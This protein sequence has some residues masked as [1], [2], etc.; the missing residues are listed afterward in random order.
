[1]KN[2]NHRYLTLAIVTLLF[3]VHCAQCKATVNNSSD[4]NTVIQI[5]QK[6][7]IIHTVKQL[8]VN[9]K[10]TLHNCKYYI[11]THLILYRLTIARK[12]RNLLANRAKNL[13]RVYLQLLQKNNKNL[14]ITFK[15]FATVSAIFH[16]E[17]RFHTL[18]LRIKQL[19]QRLNYTNV[20]VTH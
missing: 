2:T 15:Q 9:L 12:H 19:N 17:Y 1:M 7:S 20:E 16:T 6:N 13:Q 4:I 14:I 3:I 11:L 5:I 18:D 8:T 10:N